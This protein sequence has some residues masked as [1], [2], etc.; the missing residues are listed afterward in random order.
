MTDCI[1]IRR[2]AVD[3]APA[4][5]DLFVRV[6]RLLAPLDMTAAF[7]GYVA[8][9]L[10]EE[11]DRI[12]AYYSERQGSFWIAVLDGKLAGMFGLEA[13]PDPKA[14]E[15]RRMYVEPG[16]RRRGIARAML[17]FAESECRRANIE[18]LELSTSALQS[19]ALSLYRNN[20]YRLVRE[21]IVSAAS[22]KTIGGG[23]RR[24]H[25]SKTL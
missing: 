19:E 2:Y 24:F 8:A 6:N 12:P 25:F 1:N 15:L 4:V 5:R 9:S 13:T 7:E 23:I 3:D 20:N 14:M 16:L 10:A 17:Q 21:E 11:I 22:N 18:R